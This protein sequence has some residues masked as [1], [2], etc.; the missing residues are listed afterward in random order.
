M[1]ESQFNRHLLKNFQDQ[2]LVCVNVIRSH[3]QNKHVCDL[4]PER[5]LF[6]MRTLFTITWEMN[7]NLAF[8]I[9]ETHRTSR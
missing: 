9:C 6:Q 5:P 7:Q 8:K 3:C 4:G 1:I 2:I